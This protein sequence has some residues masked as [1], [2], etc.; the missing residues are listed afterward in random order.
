MKKI[1]E[2]KKTFRVE[3]TLDKYIK[4][5]KRPTFSLE[6]IED[7]KVRKSLFLH[8]NR[9]ILGI[10]LDNKCQVKRSLSKN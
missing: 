6:T 1:I 5:R 4:E 9:L 10:D 7:C 2:E 8:S 3:L